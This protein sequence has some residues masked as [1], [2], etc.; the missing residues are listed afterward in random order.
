V[1]LSILCAEND[2]IVKRCIGIGHR[3]LSSHAQSSLTRRVNGYITM[4]RP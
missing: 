4:P 3:I 2:V 1:L